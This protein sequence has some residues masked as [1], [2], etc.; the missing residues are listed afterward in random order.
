MI[1]QKEWEAAMAL[2]DTCGASLI[3]FFANSL[4]SG[5]CEVCSNRGREPDSFLFIFDYDKAQ[6]QVTITSWPVYTF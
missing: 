2:S 3:L 6:H 1:L 4:V 5:L